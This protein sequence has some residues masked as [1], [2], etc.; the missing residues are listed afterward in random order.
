MK[1]LWII[2]KSRNAQTLEA[3]VGE[4]LAEF[5]ENYKLSFR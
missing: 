4:V 5:W 1:Y 3:D 2:F